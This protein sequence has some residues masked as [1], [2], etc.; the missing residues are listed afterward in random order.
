MAFSYS[1]LVNYGKNSLPIGETDSW[2][3]DNSIIRAPPSGYTTLRR[4]KVTDSAWLLD[5]L[6]KSEDRAMDYI[7]PY[8]RG[9]NP[10][11]AVSY[12][13]SSYGSGSLS[14]SSGQQA[15][16]PFRVMNNGAFR[17]PIL[18]PF[19]LLPLS[20]IPRGNIEHELIKIQ[21]NT[22]DRITDG[23][24]KRTIRSEVLGAYC[25]A[26]VYKKREV[27]TPFNA[28]A[29]LKD[30]L[31]HSIVS[32][33][34]RAKKCAS[35]GALRAALRDAAPA[36]SATAP[37]SNTLFKREMLTT[38]PKGCI[39]RKQ[40]LASAFAH[41]TGLSQKAPE[42]E[43]MSWRPCSGARPI[44]VFTTRVFPGQTTQ[45]EI[46]ARPEFR[47]AHGRGGILAPERASYMAAGPVNTSDG[48]ACM[49]KTDKSSGRAI[50]I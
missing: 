23:P 27:P 14:G 43:H 7:T 26:P 50:E 28:R 29:H 41:K 34:R 1:G 19:D 31:L 5:E 20:R 10:F 6:D 3:S 2:N 45:D 25:T 32:N 24:E 48:S 35:G 9:V 47:R 18:K 22:C 21:H 15:K 12:N 39:T 17:P 38:R 4:D 13:N 8:A 37:M 16:L 11:V 30:T 40:N 36:I 49:F 42:P 33:P 46:A 44:D